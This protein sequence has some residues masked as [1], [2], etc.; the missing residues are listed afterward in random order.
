MLGA[1]CANSV[2]DERSFSASTA[3]ST[4][5]ASSDACSS[6]AE[7]QARSVYRLLRYPVYLRDPVP[8][9]Q[10]LGKLPDT[11]VLGAG[12]VW[13]LKSEESAIEPREPIRE[14]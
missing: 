3:P 4:T 8:L 11:R 1:A 14:Q 5:A 12:A 2:I 7:Q 6:S 9:P 13:R 10:L